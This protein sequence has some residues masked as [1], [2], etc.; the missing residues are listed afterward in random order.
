V[1]GT[2]GWNAGGHRQGALATGGMTCA[3]CHAVHGNETTDY[4]SNAD[5]T[6]QV[7]TEV[8]GLEDLT[9]ILGATPPATGVEPICLGCHVNDPVMGPGSTG[10]THPIGTTGPWAIDPDP[11]T[12]GNI[13]PGTKWGGTG[14]NPVIVCQSCHKMHCANV[15]S[16]PLIGPL[17][18]ANRNSNCNLCHSDTTLGGHH[19]SNIPYP[20]AGPGNANWPAA[21]VSEATAM[22]WAAANPGAQA[23]DGELYVFPGGEMNCST[24]HASLFSGGAHNNTARGSFFPGLSG[25]N[26]NSEMCVDCHGVNPSPRTNSVGAGTGAG[27]ALQASHYLGP[28]ITP[29]YARTA[30]WSGGGTSKYRMVAGLPANIICESCHTVK[31][32]PASLASN[33]GLGF[34]GAIRVSVPLLLE[35]S[36]NNGITYYTSSSDTT[37]GRTDMCT[38]CHGAAPAGGNSSSAGGSA[39]H[40]T[41]SY[42]MTAAASTGITVT[43]GD[44]ATRS[45]VTLTSD[46][47]VNC[48]SCHRPHDA[49]QGSGALIL[50]E[51]GSLSDKRAGILAAN[52]LSGDRKSVV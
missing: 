3:T 36:G 2:A 24:C 15:T 23:N 26:S 48:E 21:P 42:G 38:G 40:P 34:A 49:A 45:T 41:I 30:A 22:T 52:A 12:T 44:P 5:G 9:V 10:A 28:I 47:R 8:A 11:G 51:A 17:D 13:P 20:P 19:P 32:S 37:A 1:A 31:E 46:S 27:T 43:M 39:T 50:E 14:T 18:G 6:F 4:T 35:S 29:S 33:N 25:L 7:A 16:S